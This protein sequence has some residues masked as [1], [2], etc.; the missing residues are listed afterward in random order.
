MHLV[1]A[2]CFSL[3][4]AA[5]G[6]CRGT[7][8]TGEYAKRVSPERRRPDAAGCRASLCQGSGPCRA[9]ADGGRLV[10]PQI[11]PYRN[12]VFRVKPRTQNGIPH[13]PGLAPF[14]GAAMPVCSSLDS[15]ALGCRGGSL[16]GR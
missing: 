1:L 12:A 8:R 14:A 3:V 9:S 16:G 11:L 15:V 7:P 4:S 2:P 10:K 6:S 13:L 5:V